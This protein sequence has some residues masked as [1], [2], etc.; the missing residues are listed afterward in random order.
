MNKEN[1]QEDNMKIKG[2]KKPAEVNQQQ[3]KSKGLLTAI[4]IFC[5][6]M[7]K[8]IGIYAKCSL[9]WPTDYSTFLQLPL[10]IALEI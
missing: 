7:A 6:M 5:L 2:I 8:Q 9:R 3:L 4:Y 10:I 1:N